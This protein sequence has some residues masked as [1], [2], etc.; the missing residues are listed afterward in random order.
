[1]ESNYFLDIS[2]LGKDHGF[3]VTK[4]P[5]ARR[6]VNEVISPFCSDNK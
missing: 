5:E 4:S 6:L 2:L 1:M 3:Y